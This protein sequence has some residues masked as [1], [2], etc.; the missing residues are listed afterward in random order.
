MDMTLNCDNAEIRP[1]GH[2]QVEAVLTDVDKGE[3]L[4][5]FD[6]DDITNHFDSDDLLEQIGKEAAM[7]YFGL[8]E[9]EF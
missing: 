4:D 7:S 8:V 5:H 3:V 2:R 6:I 9:S 1:N